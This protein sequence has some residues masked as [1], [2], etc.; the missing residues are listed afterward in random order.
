[1]V[2]HPRRTQSMSLD[3][4]SDY[5][6]MLALSQAR[7]LDHCNVLPSVTD[8]FAGA[9]PGRPAPTGL[10]AADTAYLKAL[11]T[12]SPGLRASRYP[13]ELVDRMAK[14]LGPAKVAAL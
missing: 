8:L 12:G 2:A 9:C 14:L 13:S 6:A 1:M 11:Y 7:S 5:V 4:V 10:T 3:A